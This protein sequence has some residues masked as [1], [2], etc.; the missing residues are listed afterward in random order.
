[1]MTSNPKLWLVVGGSVIIAIIVGIVYAVRAPSTP[2]YDLVPTPPEDGVTYPSVA[3]SIAP[4]LPATPSATPVSDDP[5][6]NELQVQGSSTEAQSI[7][8]D[9]NATNFSGLDTELG[10]ID[11]ELTSEGQ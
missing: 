10:D 4:L 8:T 5:K 1:M 2:T 9:L 3:P 6:T 11:K 7:E